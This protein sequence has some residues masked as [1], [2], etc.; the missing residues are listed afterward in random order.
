M[1]KSKRKSTATRNLIIS[2]IVTLVLYM[3][4]FGGYIIYPLMLLSTLAHELGH[5]LTA[6]VLPGGSFEYFVLYTDGSGWARW[7]GDVGPIGRILIYGGGLIGPAITSMLMFIYG[8]HGKKL[9]GLLGVS[10]VLI[11]VLYV[12]NAFGLI[13]VSICATLCLAVYRK[14]NRETATTICYFV[15]VQLAL[16]V[17]SRSDYLFM[18]QAVTATGNGPSDVQ[19]M[20]MT[21]PLPYWMWGII[22]G[23]FSIGCLLIGL[24]HALKRK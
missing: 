6:A 5:G 20:A 22:C 21:I 18:K 9:F 14:T 1:T 23:L 17:F 3:V 19:H 7:S 12:R 24:R 8:R 15:A 10:L 4:P 2:V 11:A 16:S 13:F